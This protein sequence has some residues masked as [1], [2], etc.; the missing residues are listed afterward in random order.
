M[1]ERL[2]E[3]GERREAGERLEIR[4]AKPFGRPAGSLDREPEWQH[5]GDEWMRDDCLGPVEQANVVV[6]RDEEV[7]IVRFR[8]DDACRTVLPRPAT[9]PRIALRLRSWP[10]SRADSSSSRSGRASS[11]P[12]ASASPTAGARSICSSPCPNRSSSHDGAR[13]PESSRV[14]RRLP[15]SRVSRRGPSNAITSGR[16]PG[17][18]RASAAVSAGSNASGGG[19]SLNHATPSAVG[20]RA[21]A[22][23][24][25]R[26][27]ELG[28][29]LVRSMCRSIHSVARSSQPG[30][31]QASC[32]GMSYC[33]WPN[34]QR[35]PSGSS[36]V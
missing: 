33:L 11:T 13:P 18:R 30:S 20:T 3:L 27:H 21:T 17:L 31:S 19:S 7:A 9:A 5:R 24:A 23:Q 29:S 1:G 6:L 14:R 10:G 28:G 36:A 15:A 32:W 26:E 25:S 8:V 35:C 22:D 12:S 4:V 16:M 34:I 2:L